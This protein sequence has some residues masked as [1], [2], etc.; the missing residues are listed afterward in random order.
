MH[1]RECSALFTM[2]VPGILKSMAIIFSQGALNVNSGLADAHRYF[3]ESVGRVVLT[4]VS[5]NAKGYK[6]LKVTDLIPMDQNLAA[7][8]T[9]TAPAPTV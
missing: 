6:N 7:A 9:S 2:K 1:N 4:E 3:M 5:T 8:D